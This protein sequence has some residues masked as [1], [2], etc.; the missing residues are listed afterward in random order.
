MAGNMI[1]MKGKKYGRLT[2]LERIPRPD[3]MAA[4]YTWWCCRCDCGEIV[5]VD[6][7]NLRMGHTKSCGCL[8]RENM[9]KV[10]RQ[11]IARMEE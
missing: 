5:S 4:R 2:V 11:R 1:N 6:G 3:F 10:A 8:R 9:L 7:H